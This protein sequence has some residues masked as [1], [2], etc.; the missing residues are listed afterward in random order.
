MESQLN[1]APVDAR[2]AL[3]AATQS[4]EALAER[5]RAPVWYNPALGLMMGG[6][7]GAM[8]GPTWL[9][10][11]TEVLFMAGVAVLVTAYRR[12]TG[13][14][15]NGYRAGRTRLVA[16]SMAAAT[17][18]I[19]CVGVWLKVERGLWQAPLVGAP[20]VAVLVTVAGYVWQAAYRADLADQARLP[21]RPGDRA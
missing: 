5:A 1:P 16:V 12:K 9:L 2:I 13:M 14:W 18:V 7:T 19:M 10:L 6:L 3:Q 11:M 15:I 4:H 8:A 21:R 17:L 20:I